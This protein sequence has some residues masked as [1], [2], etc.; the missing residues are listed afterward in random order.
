MRSPEDGLRALRHSAVTRQHTRALKWKPKHKVAVLVPCSQTKPYYES[1]SHKHGY[2]PALEG[3][4]V[5]VFVVSE[6]MGVVP[7]AWAGEYP[8]ESYEFA[9]KHLKGQ[10]RDLLI[11]RIG[12]WV[13]KV[14]PKYNIVV[15]ALPGHHSRLL[16]AALKDREDPGFGL[17]YATISQCRRPSIGPKQCPSTVFRATAQAYQDYLRKAVASA[18]GA[19]KPRGGFRPPAGDKATN[20]AV[21]SLRRSL[22]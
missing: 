22:A 8:N 18:A 3:L 19:P 4:P 15:A 20:P 5:D 13:D 12:Q 10:A 1:P 16:E 2:L 21:R 17:Q 6:P 11:H 9:P 7:Y 14:G